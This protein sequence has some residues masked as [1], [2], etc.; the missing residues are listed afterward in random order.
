MESKSK[1]R[2]IAA[3][4]PIQ[5]TDEEKK[6]REM[7]E[8]IAGNI[9]HLSRSVKTILGGRLREES[10]IILLVHTTKLS[11]YAVT[12]VLQA[13]KNMERDHLK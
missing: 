5:E 6:A 3:T 12:A 8:D 13:L 9:A 7:I 1:E 10:L 4:T 11:K 2:R